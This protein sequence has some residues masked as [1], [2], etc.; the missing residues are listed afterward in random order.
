MT[1]KTNLKCQRKKCKEHPYY[2]N[3]EARR[4]NSGNVA[5][6]KHKKV[7]R[8][9]NKFIKKHP[10]YRNLGV[11]LMVALLMIQHNQS[12][13]GMVDVFNY[14]KI[15]RKKLGFSHTP[16]KSC[17]WPNVSKLPI[18]LLDKLLVFT[19]GKEAQ[20]TLLV[21]SSS[22]TYN[23][24]VW[25]ESAKGGRWERLTVKHHTLITLSG[26]IVASIVTDGN[27]DDSPILKKLTKKAPEG[28]GYLLADRKY[29][30]KENC[31]EAIRIGRLP[32][33]RPPKSH[34]GHGLGAWSNNDSLGEKQ[35]RQLLQ[36]IRHA[37]SCRER[38]FVV[39]EQVPR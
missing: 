22:Y 25:K 38:V 27:C 19:A 16:S 17:L 36:E 6:I 11:Y 35:S 12:Y 9:V 2:M 14:Y 5:R 15:I 24:Y 30:C 23:R 32:C 21:D 13:R 7:R 29:C 37:Q 1:R 3:Y 31:T 33:I 18:G 4:R 34:T 39:K 28:C 8:I 10:E 26:C 20:E